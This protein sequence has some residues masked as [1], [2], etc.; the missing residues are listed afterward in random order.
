MDIRNT[1]LFDETN[2]WDEDL[3]KGDYVYV[4]AFVKINEEKTHFRLS[5]PWIE[6]VPHFDYNLPIRYRN[7]FFQK[8][9]IDLSVW[10]NVHTPNRNLKFNIHSYSIPDI[11]KGALLRITKNFNLNKL[12]KLKRIYIYKLKLIVYNLT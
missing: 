1:L 12:S 5:T 2:E 6:D 10:P 7:V 9:L 11:I 3:L 8:A 4:F